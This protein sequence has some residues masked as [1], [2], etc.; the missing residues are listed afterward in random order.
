MQKW[1]QQATAW[2]VS[3]QRQKASGI[4]DDLPAHCNPHWSWTYG[5]DEL[6]IYV[7]SQKEL[8]FFQLAHPVDQK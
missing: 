7:A 4:L 8:A 6:W 2:M 1:A 5:Y 3:R